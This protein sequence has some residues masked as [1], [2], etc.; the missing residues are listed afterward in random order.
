MIEV[1]IN[2]FCFWFIYS[3]LGWVCEVIYAK[4]MQKGWDIRN[5][6]IGP[7]NPGYGIAA[8]ILVTLLNNYRHNPITVFF[9]G[10]LIASILEF[11]A[12]WFFEKTIG[13]RLW[14]YSDRA[15]NLQGRICLVNSILFGLLCVLM[16]N[17][18]HPLIYNFVLN[19]SLNTKFIVSLIV[20]TF[21]IIESTV[22]VV[23][24]YFLSKIIDDIVGIWEIIKSIKPNKNPNFRKFMEATDEEILAW[25]EDKSLSFSENFIDKYN[26]NLNLDDTSYDDEQNILILRLSQIIHDRISK[27]N[28]YQKIIYWLFPDLKSINHEEIFQVVKEQN[29]IKNKIIKNKTNKLV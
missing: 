8:I 10:G 17:I 21:Y 24:I 22:I 26:V 14:D 28:M 20:G 12:H 13:L 1:S 16:I 4:I 15:F 19:L 2:L 11:F 18:I 3:F 27:K 29:H 7:I 6:A 23:S 25:Y 9:V 5:K